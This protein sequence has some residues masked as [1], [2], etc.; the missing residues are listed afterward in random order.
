MSDEYGLF[1]VFVVE[2]GFDGLGDVVH[3]I[4]FGKVLAVAMAG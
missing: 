4:D 2:D 3:G 1:D